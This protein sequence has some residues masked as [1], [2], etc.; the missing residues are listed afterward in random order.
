MK[1]DIRAPFEAFSMPQYLEVPLFQRPYVWKEE[2]QWE[3]LWEDV[4][5]LA[6]LR[7]ANTHASPQ[8]FLG[9]IVLQSQ[10]ATLGDLATHQVIDGQQ[11][12]TTLQVLFD[13]AEGVLNVRGQAALANRLRTFTHND[14]NF[15]RAGAPLLKLKHA[16]KDGAAFAE[17]MDSEF[18]VEYEHLKHAQHRIVGAHS[19][20]A[21]AIAEWIDAAGE[22]NVPSRAEV[23]AGVLAQGLQMVVIT[24]TAEENSQE[25]FETLNARGTPLT[26]ADLIKNF[27][28][29][30]LEAEGADTREAYDK[31]WPFDTKFW[32]K[33]VSAGRYSV[34]RSSLFLNHWLVSET[35]EDVRLQG[36]FARFKSYV[37]HDAGR[38]MLDVLHDVRAQAHQYQAWQEAA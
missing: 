12:L 31:V 32:E 13:A 11:R 18:P 1:T 24:L 28:F 36:T 4:R 21:S 3:P 5:R 10:P 8:H 20:F 15:V 7:I 26:A 38:P 22:E 14:E 34:S 37:E 29:Q 27:V 9:A 19:F 35:G 23:L 6:E 33:E 25:I 16:N 2:E 30:R 17:V